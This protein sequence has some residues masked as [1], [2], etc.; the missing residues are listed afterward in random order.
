M[1]FYVRIVQPLFGLIFPKEKAQEI[2]LGEIK[3][4]L[5]VDVNMG[6]GNERIF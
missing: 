5:I 2:I 6:E 4:V 1:I 3:S